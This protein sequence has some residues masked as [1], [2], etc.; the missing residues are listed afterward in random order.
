[1][2]SH[3]GRT[4]PPLGRPLDVT[5]A[6]QLARMIDEGALVIDRAKP[7]RIH[8]WHFPF[9]AGAQLEERLII[10]Q[11]PLR[12]APAS[13]LFQAVCAYLAALV[14]ASGL[15]V[16]YLKTTLRLDSRASSE[17][18][19]APWFVLPT[20]AALAA[21]RLVGQL[22][23]ALHAEGEHGTRDRAIAVAFPVLARE[24]AGGLPLRP[25]CTLSLA[26]GPCLG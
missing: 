11:G 19:R 9:H 8:L 13:P 15:A 3:H 26:N 12:H 20:G 18:L 24:P 6:Q 25:H 1:M 21:P 23:D 22:I 14:D 2:S 7:I 17:R 5:L 10:E 16:E 4:T